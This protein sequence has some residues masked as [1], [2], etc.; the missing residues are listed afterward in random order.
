MILSHVFVIPFHLDFAAVVVWG[1]I[2][3]S[4]HIRDQLPYFCIQ[5]EYTNIQ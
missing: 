1:V 4:V 5:Y 3:Q 2:S